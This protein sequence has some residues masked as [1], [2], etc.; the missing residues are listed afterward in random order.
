MGSREVYC[1][2][3]RQ[4]IY[5]TRWELDGQLVEIEEK[6]KTTPY[7]HKDYPT[8][9][10]RWTGLH[11]TKYGDQPEQRSLG[12]LVSDAGPKL[13]ISVVTERA[14]EVPYTPEE[15]EASRER[16]RQAVERIYGCRCEWA[17]KGGGP[18]VGKEKEMVS[19]VG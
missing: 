2:D 4:Q 12:S 19:Q 3:E 17:N 1:I 11:L 8:R 7:R 5:F 14:P 18:D 10:V 16:I 15:V 6:Q 9:C 13:G